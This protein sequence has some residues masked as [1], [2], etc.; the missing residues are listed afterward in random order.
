MCCICIIGEETES[1]KVTTEG[2]EEDKTA[3]VSNK[4]AGGSLL[5]ELEPMP[6]IKSGVSIAADMRFGWRP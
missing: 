3:Q 6:L 2:G 4:A 5:K 1:A